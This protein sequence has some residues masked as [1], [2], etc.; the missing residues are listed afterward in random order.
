L[1]KLKAALILAISR[2]IVNSLNIPLSTSDGKKQKEG[3]YIEHKAD[4]EDIDQRHV[5]AEK[6][7]VVLGDKPKK[8]S[9]IVNN[10]DSLQDAIKLAVL[11][12]I[13]ANSAGRLNIPS[14]NAA[15]DAP[16]AG[17][18]YPEKQTNMT[19]NPISEPKKSNLPKSREGLLLNSD[20]PDELI[21]PDKPFDDDDPYLN[22]LAPAIPLISKPVKKNLK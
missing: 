5:P 2:K 18:N 6:P 13:T 1:E 11:S 21:F 22:T 3:E 9:P 12:A 7:T 10:G 17:E 14:S 19:N 20:E 8:I 4:I 15:K 16:E